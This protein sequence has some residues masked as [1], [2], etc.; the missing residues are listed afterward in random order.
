MVLRQ[1]VGRQSGREV[2]RDELRGEAGSHPRPTQALQLR[3]G[4]PGLLAHLARRG[5]VGFLA[6][7]AGARRDL[8]EIAPCRVPVLADQQPPPCLVED[9]ERD[10]A[11]V[12]DDRALGLVAVREPDRVP[13]HGY[14]TSRSEVLR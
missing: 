6:R 12:L 7:L 10:R 14:V 4:E 11:W 8:E 3:R 1:R 2:E 9:D 5:Q 13:H